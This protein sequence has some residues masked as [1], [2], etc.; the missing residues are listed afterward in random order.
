MLKD[1]DE[2]KSSFVRIFRSDHPIRFENPHLS[3]FAHWTLFF[4]SYM[5]RYTP[6]LMWN[7]QLYKSPVRNHCSNGSEDSSD[8]W[9]PHLL[10][11]MLQRFIL[12]IY[13]FVLA[14]DNIIIDMRDEVLWYM[15]FVGDVMIISQTR[16]Q[17]ND[18]LE[19]WRKVLE[20]NGSR[21][22]SSKTNIRSESSMSLRLKKLSWS[23]LKITRCYSVIHYDF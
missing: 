19:L 13:L 22:S 8:L 1:L 15:P 18:K 21:I 6:I 11:N 4:F 17:V 20:S 5:H 9:I 23:N 12:S 2:W 14:A 7:H 16:G 10:P 3:G